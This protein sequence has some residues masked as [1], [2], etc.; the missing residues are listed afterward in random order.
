MS[1]PRSVARSGGS[2]PR[3]GDRSRRGAV[4][5]TVPGRAEGTGPRA[6]CVPSPRDVPG[7][8][9]GSRRGAVG[10]TV[11]GS[12]T[13]RSD[14]RSRLGAVGGALPGRLGE[15]YARFGVRAHAGQV[16]ASRGTVTVRRAHSCRGAV[17]GEVGGFRPPPLGSRDGKSDRAGPGD[18]R[19]G[20]GGGHIEP[21]TASRSGAAGCIGIVLPCG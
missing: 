5:G 6:E 15:R 17:G 18:T 20:V 2:S 11:V 4:G 19:G 14:D 13:H 8:I 3:S 16:R 10:R 7:R 1:R 21:S 9:A 12:R